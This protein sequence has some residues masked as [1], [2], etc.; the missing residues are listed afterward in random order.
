[1]KVG[2]IPRYLTTWM[3]RVDRVVASYDCN[4]NPYLATFIMY[5]FMLMGVVRATILLTEVLDTFD[6]VYT[7]MIPQ[8]QGLGILCLI[9]CVAETIMLCVG[10]PDMIVRF[11]IVVVLVNVFYLIGLLLPMFANIMLVI[12]AIAY[13]YIFIEYS[14]SLTRSRISQQ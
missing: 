13:I 3:S 7:F 6:E 14:L 2:V 1:M 8:D 12:V 4:T 5:I 11:L 10:L 9:I